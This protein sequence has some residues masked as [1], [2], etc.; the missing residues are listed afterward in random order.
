MNIVKAFVEQTVSLRSTDVQTNSLYICGL[1]CL[2]GFS[3]HRSI[4]FIYLYLSQTVTI[5]F[6]SEAAK[7]N[8]RQSIRV[9]SNIRS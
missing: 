1:P 4:L 6:V 8:T 2:R 7:L 5:T 3:L 9:R